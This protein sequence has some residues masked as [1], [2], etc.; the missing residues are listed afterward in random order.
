MRKI[1][2]ILMAFC[3]AG[4]LLD[5]PTAR[6]ETAPAVTPQDHVLGKAD[7]P[8][9]IIEYASPTCPH[10]AE[11]DRDSLPKIKQNWIDTGKARLVFRI[12]PLNQTDVRVALVAECVPPD[13]YFSFIDELYQ[14]QAN[15]ARASDP[16]QAAAT[17]GRLAGAGGDKI[18]SCLADK[19]L[20]ESIINQSYAAQKDYG[21]EATPTF[22]INGTKL[23]GARPSDEFDKALTAAQPQS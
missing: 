4:P 1:W 8:V 11:F 19:K 12:F 6:A 22:F 16:V 3:L 18:Q 20:E 5:P 9:T 14:T 21:I 10:C 2:L 13:R 15:W 7:A 23:V 17:I